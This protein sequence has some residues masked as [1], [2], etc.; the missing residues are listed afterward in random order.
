MESLHRF[1]HFELSYETISHKKVSNQYE[2][3][4]AIPAGR[5]YYLWWTFKGAQDVCY[6]LEISKDKRIVRASIVDVPFSDRCSLGTVLYG[7]YIK[8]EGERPY[9]VA[10]D[11]YAYKGIVL[12]HVCFHEKLGLLKQLFER[13]YIQRDSGLGVYLPFMWMNDQA[14]PDT[15]IPEHIA[16]QIVYSIHH[17]Q[18]RT[19][20]SIR[21]H[22]NIPVGIKETL[23]TTSAAA[24]MPII[25]ESHVSAYIPDFSKPQYKYPTVFRVMADIQFDIYHLYAWN[26]AK[27]E[28][29]YYD[30][31]YIPNYTKSV[32]MNG[33]FRNI[34]ENRNLDYIEESDD[35]EEFENTRIDKY[36]DLKK[37]YIMECTFHTKF[38]R[39][40]PVRLMKDRVVHIHKLAR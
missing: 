3:C 23:L 22:L 30:V 19:L 32:F 35:E 25:T 16:K 7:T 9:F 37:E 11:I 20:Y 6:L 21:P 1:P 17:I 24:M 39:W 28:Y 29:V 26:N 2:V 13:E 38:K 33:L 34:R 15:V 4:M 8:E 5:K 40:V 14:T 36:V 31:A 18:Y 10:E 12:N 27:R